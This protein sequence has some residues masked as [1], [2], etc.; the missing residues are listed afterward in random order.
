MPYQG[1][2]D[3]PTSLKERDDL[4]EFTDEQWETFIEVF[5]AVWESNPDLPDDQRESKATAVAIDRAKA[6]EAS[7]HLE[8]GWTPT[9]IAAIT[10]G[11]LHLGDRTVHVTEDVLHAVVSEHRRHQR[12]LAAAGLDRSVPVTHPGEGGPHVDSGRRDGDVE[13]VLVGGDTLYAAIDWRPP[14][15]RDIAEQ[16]MDRVSVNIRA[17]HKDSRLGETYSPH[18][19]EISPTNHPRDPE[20]GIAAAIGDVAASELESA[21]FAVEETSDDVDQSQGDTPTLALTAAETDEMKFAT[22]LD[23]KLE[24]F[25][26]PEGGPGPTRSELAGQM[27]SGTDATA[28]QIEQVAKGEMEL[29]PNAVVSAAAEMFGVSEEDLRMG[30]YEMPDKEKGG[31]EKG[32]REKEKD[33]NAGGPNGQSGDSPQPPQG[34]GEQPPGMAASEGGENVQSIVASLRDEVQELREENKNLREDIQLAQRVAGAN[35]E[36]TSSPG[37]GFAG[38]EGGFT[39]TEGGPLEANTYDEDTDAL[40][41]AEDAYDGVLEADEQVVYANFKSP[42]NGRDTLPENIKSKIRDHEE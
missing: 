17:K 26:T 16:R 8:A 34:G 35:T 28:E 20:A 11:P 40:E 42:N 12:D 1:T 6:V 29:P 4:Q 15:E 36:P 32:N 25:S 7:K 19:K 31:E 33:Q 27:A 18:L 38:S 39:G 30:N 37:D 3:I 14:A 5:N 21:G 23:H 13:G 9:W 22:W 24:R 2:S 41:A 10:T